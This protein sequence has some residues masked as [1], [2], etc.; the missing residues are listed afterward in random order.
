[1]SQFIITPGWRSR[2]LPLNGGRFPP[3]ASD[4]DNEKNLGEE[5]CDSRR[6]ANAAFF[7]A[8]ART[9]RE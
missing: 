5:P 7:E 3:D 9:E 4:R 6:F 8:K 2:V 1:M